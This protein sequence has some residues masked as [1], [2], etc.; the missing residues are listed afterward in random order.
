MKGFRSVEQFDA[1]TLCVQLR[2]EVY[3]LTGTGRAARDFKFRDQIRGSAS[4]P[5]AHI[6]EGFGRFK[7]KVFAQFVNYAKSSLAETQNHLRHGR[8]EKY[9]SEQDFDAVWKL[10]CRAMSATTGLFHYLNGPE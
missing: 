9:F 4:G 2:N 8:H 10:S 3:R 5:P 1:Y 6:S 7:P